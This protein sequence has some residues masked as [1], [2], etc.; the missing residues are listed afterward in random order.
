MTLRKQNAELLERLQNV[1][2]ELQETRN[3]LY[4]VQGELNAMNKDELCT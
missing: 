1:R 4:I 2:E 3:E